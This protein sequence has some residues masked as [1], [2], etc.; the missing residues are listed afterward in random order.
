MI[1]C[2]HANITEELQK[3]DHVH[4]FWSGLWGDNLLQRPRNFYFK[5]INLISKACVCFQENPKS[6]DKI[7]NSWS[8][9]ASVIAILDE[10]GLVFVS[11][12]PVY[13]C[14]CVH[15]TPR[16]V[17]TLVIL[18]R[19][20]SQC[21]YI[22]ICQRHVFVTSEKWKSAPKNVIHNP[23]QAIIISFSLERRSSV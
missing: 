16:Y 3:P 7:C 19:V 20:I 10:C 8:E 2:H 22:C 12:R 5:N 14:I 18:F 15:F 9:I 6:T 13:I 21:K 23:R 11:L 1:S 17:F 4:N